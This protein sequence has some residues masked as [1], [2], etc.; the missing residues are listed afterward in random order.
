[1][2][3]R[4]GVRL[5]GDD[6]DDGEEVGPCLRISKQ[7][8]KGFSGNFALTAFSEVSNLPL[9]LLAAFVSGLF[10]LFGALIGFLGLLYLARRSDRSTEWQLVYTRNRERREEA[11]DDLSRP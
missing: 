3:E 6:T 5:R 8:R 9:E 4:G 1:M 7:F 2:R 11:S 10:T